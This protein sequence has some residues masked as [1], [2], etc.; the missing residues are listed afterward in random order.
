MDDMKRY[1]ETLELEPGASPEEVKRAW[2]DLAKVW[3]PDR[4]SHDPPLQQKAQEKLKEINKAYEK[5]SSYHAGSFQTTSSQ[6]DSWSQT[7]QSWTQSG[8]YQSDRSWTYQRPSAS[9]T[10]E[11]SLFSRI[12]TVVIVGVVV[13]FLSRL[14]NVPD[15]KDKTPKPAQV[16]SVER[17]LKG[18]KTQPSRTKD[19]VRYA[20]PVERPAEKQKVKK[21]EPSPPVTKALDQK[22]TTPPISKPT[23]HTKTAPPI[24]PA[25]SFTLGST[26]DDVLAVQGKPDQDLTKQFRYGTS[27]VYFS[28]G[29]VTGWNSESPPLKVKIKASYSTSKTVLDI[30]STM[31]EVI[32]IQGTPDY[33]SE[34]LFRYGTSY[35]YFS[36]R[37]V[38]GWKNGI[39]PLKIKKPE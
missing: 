13:V 20:Y 36:Y 18:R 31:H 30:G 14:I 26:K 8:G 23:E 25:D 28:R 39:P 24:I 19:Q 3:H 32:A 5:L 27:Y 17:F 16:P 6:Q 12:I 4:F 7:S 22:K 2:R 21:I 10:Y 35:V 11:R 34:G 33:F 38:T 1:Y 9:D 15:K 29:R 37:K